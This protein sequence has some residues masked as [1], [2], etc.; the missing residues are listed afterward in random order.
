MNFFVFLQLRR[1]IHCVDTQVEKN[2]KQGNVKCGLGENQ[3][4]GKKKQHT[5]RGAVDNLLIW[6]NV[7]WE[8]TNGQ[9]NGRDFVFGFSFKI[10]SIIAY[11]LSCFFHANAFIV[12]YQLTA[13]YVTP[14]CP[15][16]FVLTNTHICVRWM[17][18]NLMKSVCF[19]S[20]ST[21]NSPSCIEFSFEQN[22]TTASRDFFF[23]HLTIFIL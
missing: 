19:Y 15:H 16:S 10:P 13:I 1:E 22:K 17:K 9:K 14:Q 12:Y 5:K 3:L 11:I 7:K 8:P 6:M 4:V 2:R 21:M 20:A 18:F 23:K